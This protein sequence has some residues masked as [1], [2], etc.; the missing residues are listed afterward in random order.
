MQTT[1]NH[2]RALEFA[3]ILDECEAIALGGSLARTIDADL[4]NGVRFR[5]APLATFPNRAQRSLVTIDVPGAP[6][7]TFLECEN[8]AEA[9]ELAREA[10][11]Q[12]IEQ[13]RNVARGEGRA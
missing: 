5:C 6:R 7:W 10:I 2:R 9:I 8:G 11:A 1:E 13:A 4:G 3:R 12:A